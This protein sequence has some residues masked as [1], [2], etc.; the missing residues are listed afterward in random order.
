MSRYSIAKILSA[1][2][3]ALCA[4]PALADGIE[5]FHGGF[6]D[7]VAKARKQK[8]MVFVDVYTDWCAPCKRMAKTV[9]VQEDVGK[10]FNQHFI[11]YQLNAEDTAQRGPELAGRFEV[12]SYPTYLFL[13]GAGRLIAKKGGAMSPEAFKTVAM[14]VTG[15]A[16]DKSACAAIA[17]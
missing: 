2:V 5:F 13:D 4:L 12:K 17:A 10:T 14:T 16:S 11:S 6:D 1:G 7:A 8:K 3:L 15:L 9:F